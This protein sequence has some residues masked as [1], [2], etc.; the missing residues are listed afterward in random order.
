MEE[1][2]IPWAITGPGIRSAKPAPFYISN[3]FTAHVL[4]EIFRIKKLPSGWI[5]YS[6]KEIFK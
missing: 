4:A 6:G 2:Q 5:G 1:M 3:K